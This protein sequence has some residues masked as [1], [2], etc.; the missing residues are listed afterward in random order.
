MIRTLFYR[1]KEIVFKIGA[2][3][4]KSALNENNAH[5]YAEKH[6]NK[7][8]KRTLPG[9]HNKYTMEYCLAHSAESINERFRQN[10]ADDI[11]NQIAEMMNTHTT[12]A[13][14]ILYRGVND[15]VY[16]LMVANANGIKGTDLLEKGFLCT[17]LVKGHELNYNKKLRIF[18]PAGS[19]VVY[20]GN[21]NYEPNFYEV[22]I[23]KDASLKIVSI[24]K[25]YINCRLLKTA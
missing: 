16:K 24:G 19:K 2:D 25:D 9:N 3:W 12:D 10:R 4:D 21:V 7:E 6:I 18:V 17:S 23:Q 22:D 15:Y 1:V 5:E 8:P 11:D 13:D 14:L 20:M